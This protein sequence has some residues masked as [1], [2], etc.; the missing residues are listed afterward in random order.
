MPL[1]LGGRYGL[2][3]K[4]LTPKDAM[5][6]FHNGEV[7]E[8]KRKF[9][10]GIVDDVTQLSLPPVSLDKLPKADE[11]VT[12]CVFFAMGSD[13]TVSAN[14]NAIKLIG[15]NTDLYVQGHIVY[16][17]KKAG[18]ATVSHLRF[19][20]KPINKPYEIVEAGYVAVHEPTWPKK[21]PKAIMAK[22]RP[23]GTLVLNSH[24]TTPA[25]LE[26]ILPCEMLRAISEKEAQ[27]WVVDA[28]AIAKRYGLGKHIN[29]V[30][31]AVFFKLGFDSSILDYETKALP[32]LLDSLA[33]TYS[34][35][36]EETIR[37]NSE[38]TKAATASLVR[39]EV[40]QAW[41]TA[42]VDSTATGSFTGDQAYDKLSY[43]VGRMEGS[44][45][46]VSAIDVRGRYPTGMTKHE[47][48]GIAP[49]IPIV[50]MDKCT[51]CNLCSVICPHA[52]IRPFLLDTVENDAVP[53]ETR[54]AKGGSEVQGFH[55]RIQVTPLDC[56]GC[57]ACSWAC[58]DDALT[59]VNVSTLGDDPV[60]ARETDNWNYLINLPER[61]T[62]RHNSRET[63]RQSQLSLP[64][65]EFSGACAG[66]GETPYAKLVTQLFG[67][68]MVISNASGCSGVWGAAAGF[69][70][71]TKN[72]RGEGPAWGRSLYED[73]AEYGLGAATAT[74]TRR[75]FLREQVADLL[76][77]I[78]PDSGLSPLTVDLLYRWVNGGW[79]DS[80]ISQDIGRVLPGRLRQE[81]ELI[82]EGELRTSI[83]KVLSVGGEFV[84]V[85]HWIFGGD[86]WAYD[87][88]FG[89]LDHVLASGT[90]INVM[91]LDTEGYAN[92]GGQKSKATQ[93]SAVQKFATD[94]YRRPKKNLAEMFMVER[95]LAMV[96]R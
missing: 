62:P 74:H 61:S 9:T 3:S 34:R 30:M 77:K 73:A 78:G 49:M 27:L 86:G 68:R 81:L 8:P 87:I 64:M 66:C 6:V 36:G 80:A 16:D 14:K 65:L 76:T 40:P 10:V 94:G 82:P 69:S 96:Q 7:N 33:K 89:G 54:P 11:S 28:L 25:E 35:K 75:Q 67:E 23:G 55:Y 91:V 42:V 50:D 79:K 44:E 17:S 48:R 39:I 45:L 90:D 15:S 57:E 22:L 2:G 53:T 24:C 5:A 38:A 88:G 31:Q 12:E 59:M 46:P 37:R 29:N 83:E 93:I 32:M 95:A 72:D 20:G 52:A 1:V 60:V 56:T 84:K 70:S 85:S 47:K 71:Y 63:A 19:G 21:F 41:A 58:P 13:G 18:G 43:R 51:Q 26:R 92:T 4:D